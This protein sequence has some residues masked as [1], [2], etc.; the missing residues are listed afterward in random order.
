MSM[1]I[2][3]TS[4]KVRSKFQRFS[5]ATGLNK[6]GTSVKTNARMI[7]YNVTSSGNNDPQ[8]GRRSIETGNGSIQQEIDQETRML[9]PQEVIDYTENF[10]TLPYSCWNVMLPTVVLL[11]QV[12][13]TTMYV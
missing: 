11:N 2:E 7:G 5:I 10:F 1:S 9:S 6:C 3:T 13:S 12:V 4:A 8:G